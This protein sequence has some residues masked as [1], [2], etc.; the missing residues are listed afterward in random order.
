MPII[1]IEE[2]PKYLIKRGKLAGLDLGTKTIGC[3]ASDYNLTIA[4]PRFT[5][6]KT[7]FT[8]DVEKLLDFFRKEEILAISVGLP[9]NMDGTYGPRAQATKAFV[10]N[11]QKYTELPF[12]L[13]DERLST[14][15]AERSLIEQNISRQKRV[16]RI[17]CAAAAFILQSTLDRV[18]FLKTRI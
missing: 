14:V 11:M 5:L 8:K 6:N 13:Q 3:A 18:Q 15:E 10:S 16:N 12:I 7:K 4:S 1:I 17:D 9:I 2:L